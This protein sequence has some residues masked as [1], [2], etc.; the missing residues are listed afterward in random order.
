MKIRGFARFWLIVLAVFGLA[1][2]VGCIPN[3]VSTPT[4]PQEQ[5][6]VI[7][8]PAQPE[9]VGTAA[10]AIKDLGDISGAVYDRNTES[11]VLLG[12]GSK[13]NQGSMSLE[14]LA[15]ALKSLGDDSREPQL[16]LDPAD[17]NN[18][19]GPDLRAVYYGPIEGTNFGQVMFDA[20]WLLKG[21]S[22]GKLTI[23]GQER[24]ITSS[25]PGYKNMF[26]L[27]FDQEWPEGSSSS[28]TRYWITVDENVFAQHDNAILLEKIRMKVNTERM[29]AT[30]KG[31]ES[32]G[33]L[34]DPK[35]E[36]FAAHF[37][38]NYDRFA[39]EKPAFRK[40]KEL[41]KAVALAKWITYQQI[42]VDAD[43]VDEFSKP[44]MNTP[45]TVGALEA[46][47]E[48]TE[49]VTGGRQV[50]TVRL[51][52]GVDLSVK[53]VYVARKALKPLETNIKALMAK[54]DASPIFSIIHEGKKY[55][56]M[57]M[58]ITNRGKL[59]WEK[60]G[61]VSYLI[62]GDEII[63]M[64]WLTPGVSETREHGYEIRAAA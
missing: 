49:Q 55:P 50:L 27:N 58:P 23:D 14:D 62:D 25:V 38:E 34:Q 4:Q 41:A 1:S 59:M 46:T 39:K 29:W 33:G 53:P 40:V 19:D 48:R 22:F 32:S 51:Y 35:A 21:L 64:A 18:P 43:W 52:G 11:L 10:E 54:P 24:Q 61:R 12:S 7:E 20:D 63:L 15:V 30:S 26:D 13:S 5:T 31:L 57:V 60:A 16:S 3:R 17:R 36:R 47:E 56:A 42:D 37:T 8:E 6:E 28:Y 44:N 2:L 9:P 45:T